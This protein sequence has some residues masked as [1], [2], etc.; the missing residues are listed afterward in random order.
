MALVNNERIERIAIGCLQ[1]LLSFPGY[2][3]SRIDDSGWFAGVA[4]DA[5]RLAEQLIKRLDEETE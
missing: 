3:P 2:R 1:G 5:V 4:D